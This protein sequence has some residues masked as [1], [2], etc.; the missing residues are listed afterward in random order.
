M[1]IYTIYIYY[2]Y[3]HG[4]L[5]FMVY[6][7]GFTT[8]SPPGKNAAFR[9]LSQGALAEHS[10]KHQAP[11][12]RKSDELNP[13]LFRDWF[14]LISG[15]F[16]EHFKNWTYQIFPKW[17][18]IWLMNRTVDF[19]WLNLSDFR[20]FC[21]WYHHWWMRCCFNLVHLMIFP[22]HNML[23]FFLV[24]EKSDSNKNWLVVLWSSYM[25]QIHDFSWN[26]GRLPCFSRY[27]E[28]HSRSM[29]QNCWFAPKDRLL[30]DQDVFSH[31]LWW[32]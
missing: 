28:T 27:I 14:S 9:R 7:N 24:E 2:I 4:L 29:A 12:Q 20:Q 16:G 19:P 10:A 6:V 11:K 3:I 5:S 1:C 8:Y 22:T 26:H 13:H 21:I 18:K 15:K 23:D 25:I 17:L 30:K 32:Q 31:C